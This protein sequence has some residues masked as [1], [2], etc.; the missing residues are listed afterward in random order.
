MAQPEK[1]NCKDAFFHYGIEIPR[2]FLPGEK[3]FFLRKAGLFF[4]EN[5]YSVSY[6]SDTIKGIK[7]ANLI[8]GDPQKADT[9]VVAHYNTPPHNFGN[10]YLY[11]PF[12][13]T[14]SVRSRFLPTYTP[15]IIAAVLIF[16]TLW[17]WGAVVD[18]GRR[19]VFS[20]VVVVLLVVATICAYIMSGSIGNS[21][22]LNGNTSGVVGALLMAQELTPA[23]KK[24]VAF[25]LTDNN[26]HAGDTLNRSF[27][28]AIDHKTVILLD[29]IGQGAENRIGYQKSAKKT[30]LELADRLNASAQRVDETALR[31]S[32]FSYYPSGILISRTTGPTHFV[33]HIGT[34]KDTAVDTEAVEHIAVTLSCYLNQLYKK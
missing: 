15:A 5:D 7:A 19:P 32:S 28:P 18:F 12:D 9:L 22:N 4:K 29:C 16:Y 11:Y 13:G 21:I 6:A 31:F 26:G 30:A 3:D 33:E 2:R 24:H 14:A 8:A 1:L 25:I 10:P 17:Q 23:A 27:I 34:A 20:S